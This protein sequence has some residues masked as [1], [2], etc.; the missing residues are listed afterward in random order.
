MRRCNIIV[1]DLEEPR[2][3]MPTI[4][5]PASGAMRHPLYQLLRN[6]LPRTSVNEERLGDFGPYLRGFDALLVAELQS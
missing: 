5:W 4:G 3:L 6:P 2:S 1:V